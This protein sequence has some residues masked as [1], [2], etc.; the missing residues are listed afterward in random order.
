MNRETQRQQYLEEMGI[1]TY[2]SRFRLP[3]AAASPHWPVDEAGGAASPTTGRIPTEHEVAGVPTEHEVAGESP[4][5]SRQPPASSAN[6]ALQLLETQQESAPA[7]VPARPRPAAVAG[8]SGTDASAPASQQTAGIGL[9][10]FAFSWYGPDARLAVLA[11]LPAGQRGRPDR[12][13]RDLLAN[14]LRA[15][16]EAYASMALT[17]HPFAWPFDPADREADA[18][19]ARQAVQGFAR[20][21][22]RS[23]PARY[24]LVCADQWPSYLIGDK[25]VGDGFLKQADLGLQMLRIPSL[26]AMAQDRARKKEAWQQLQRLIPALREI[27]GDTAGH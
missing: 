4:Y 19:A 26:P 8:Q 17:D 5:E 11:E 21:R 25:A 12:A 6:D 23:Q 10:P 13:S 2:Y 24:L 1:R 9:E 14:M 22:L 15:V 20:R 3:G 16:D 27:R 7:A 18:D